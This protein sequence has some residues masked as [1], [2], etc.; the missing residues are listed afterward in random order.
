MDSYDLLNRRQ[1]WL[2]DDGLLVLPY[3]MGNVP[4]WD[5]N[6]RGVVLGCLNHTRAHL[7]SKVE[8]VGYALYGSFT[9]LKDNVDKIAIP[10]YSTKAARKANVAADHHRHIMH[11]LVKNRRPVWQCLLAGKIAGIFKNYSIARA[12]GYIDPMERMRRGT[13]CMDYTGYIKD[14]CGCQGVLWIWLS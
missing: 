9:V 11:G 5:V 4:I 13:I 10:S 6:A 12:D 8:S 14:L 2:P 7:I 3:L 1:R